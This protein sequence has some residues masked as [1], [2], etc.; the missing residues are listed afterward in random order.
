M[1]G[2][3]N[4]KFSVE[5]PDDDRESF[6]VTK[7]EVVKRRKDNGQG[8]PWTEN[9]ELVLGE[10]GDQGANGERDTDTD[11]RARGADEATA[12]RA[13][14][15]ITADGGRYISAGDGYPGSVHGTDRYRNDVERTG[16]TG[17]ESR[18]CGERNKANDDN[19]KSHIG[20]SGKA[21]EK[22]I[23]MVNATV[24]DYEDGEFEWGLE[25]IQSE[26][27]VKETY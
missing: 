22:E 17:D 15:G 10:D 18:T 4:W 8:G 5:F 14:Y 19:D 2:I 20:V 25:P 26:K 9:G 7:Y 23:K 1:Y 13:V 6:G 12:G 3:K 21:T 11:S 27:R 24:D 16:E